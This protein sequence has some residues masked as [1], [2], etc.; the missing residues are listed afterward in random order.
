[1]KQQNQRSS[2]SHILLPFAKR[3]CSKIPWDLNLTA[4]NRYTLE[5]YM[6]FAPT[7]GIFTIFKVPLLFNSNA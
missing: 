4:K 2:L 5:K 3:D 1:M 7:K 6:G